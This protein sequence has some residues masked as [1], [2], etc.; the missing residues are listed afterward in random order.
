MH[1]T[2]ILNYALSKTII[3]ISFHY[4]SF[5][6]Y[7]IECFKNN[8][9]SICDCQCPIILMRVSITS[10]IMYQKCFWIHNNVDKM[11]LY[12]QKRDKIKSC[13]FSV[14]NNKSVHFKIYFATSKMSNIFVI[15][16]M[17]FISKVRMEWLTGISEKGR[18]Y[19]LLLKLPINALIYLYMQVLTVRV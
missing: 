18:N 10:F 16:T 4:S 5:P 19:N 17:G 12:V 7:C 6:F 13:R 2:Q 14:L 11:L 8:I 1:P 15:K 9:I 3:R